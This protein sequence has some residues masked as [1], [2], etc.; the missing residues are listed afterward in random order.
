MSLV[1]ACVAFSPVALGVIGVVSVRYSLTPGQEPVIAAILVGSVVGAVSLLRLVSGQ[2][3]PLSV[4]R[5]EWLL[6]ATALLAIAATVTSVQSR[7]ISG[8]LGGVPR[9]S[10]GRY[11]IENHRVHL[12]YITASEYDH[13][14]WLRQFAFGLSGATLGAAS[15]ALALWSLGPDYGEIR[16]ILKR[17]HGTRRASLPLSGRA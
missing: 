5:P 12:R 15:S 8:G 9:R 14:V 13:A 2:G 16:K 11:S 17:H 10:N 6:A 3:G 7:M 1:R 4:R